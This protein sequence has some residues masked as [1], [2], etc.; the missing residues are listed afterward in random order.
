MKPRSRSTTAVS[1]TR[2]WF[3]RAVAESDPSR[4]IRARYLQGLWPWSTWTTPAAGPSTTSSPQAR[5]GRSSRSSM[6]PTA[7]SMAGSVHGLLR[8]AM[9]DWAWERSST[10]VTPGQAGQQLIPTGNTSRPEHHEVESSAFQLP[11]HVTPFSEQLCDIFP[12]EPITASWCS[13]GLTTISDHNAV[14]LRPTWTDRRRRGYPG[15]QS[16]HSSAQPESCDLILGLQ[17]APAALI[18]LP[19][20]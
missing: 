9:L 4:T 2:S 8:A 11:A 18:R 15:P 17:A 7:R 3:A 12:A 1:V 14:L 10:G 16:S 19:A 6:T 5:R 20:L 13:A